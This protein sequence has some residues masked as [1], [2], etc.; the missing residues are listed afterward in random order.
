MIKFKRKEFSNY[1]LSNTIKGASIGATIGTGMAG[2]NLSDNMRGDN[3]FARTYNSQARNSNDRSYPKQ[4][5]N[6]K[7]L[8]AAAGTLIGAAL[9]AIVGTV[10]AVTEKTSQHG[11]D[12]RLLKDVMKTLSSLGYK[13][14]I[15]YTRDPETANRLKT[16]VCLVITR[17]AANISL[18]VNM[19]NDNKL[20]K[21]ADKIL[22]SLPGKPQIR[23]SRTTDKYNDITISTISKSGS[24]A[25]LVTNIVD[26]FIKAGYPVYLVEVG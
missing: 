24:N 12:H 22:R 2:L 7:L 25:D 4:T 6:Q 1:I 3:W 23:Y 13:E 21:D 5:T 10:K 15:D 16:R 11:T 14:G 19:V 8:I 9:G 18:L 17:D 26:G 20:S